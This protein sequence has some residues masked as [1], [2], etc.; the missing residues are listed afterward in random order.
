MLQKRRAGWV[1]RK[2]GVDECVSFD[3]KKRAYRVDLRGGGPCVFAYAGTPRKA[4]RRAY[5]YRRAYMEHDKLWRA[6]MAIATEGEL[7]A[8][9]A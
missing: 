7:A 4:L 1:T 5:W 2:W 6:H 3:F 8:D 9:V